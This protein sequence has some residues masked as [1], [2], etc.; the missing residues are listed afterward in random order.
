MAEYGHHDVVVPPF[1]VFTV[2]NAGSF[3]IRV[4]HG[5]IDSR[6]AHAP[7][8]FACTHQVLL[9]GGELFK[10]LRI[11]LDTPLRSATTAAK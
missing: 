11:V 6:L 3:V 2:L 5:E 7:G 1:K 10:D 9:I 8:N 4:S